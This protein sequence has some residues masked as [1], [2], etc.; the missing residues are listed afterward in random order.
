MIREQAIA[1]T[2]ANRSW[3]GSALSAE[4]PAHGTPGGIRT[5]A[6]RFGDE[7]TAIFTTDHGEGWRGTG[8]AVAA[9]AGEPPFGVRGSNP[10]GAFAP[11]PRSNRHLHHRH[12]NACA[13]AIVGHTGEQ[14]ISVSVTATQYPS[15]RRETAPGRVRTFARPHPGACVKG[16]IR[17]RSFHGAKYPKSSP[18]AFWSSR[19]YAAN[20]ITNKFCRG[21]LNRAAFANP[22]GSALPSVSGLRLVPSDR[23]RA[24]RHA[25]SGASPGIRVS[26]SGLRRDIF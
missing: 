5:R 6:S 12:A 10:L 7:V 14:A 19:D 22:L 3:P 26:R 16:G 20:Q 21:A 15:L 4:L 9:L 25:P 13:S 18:P 23:P 1:E 24:C 11:S 2:P 17:T 8:D